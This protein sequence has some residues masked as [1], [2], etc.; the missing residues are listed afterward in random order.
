[1]IALETPAEHRTGT[2]ASGIHYETWTTP[3]HRPWLCLTHGAFCDLSDYL[4]FADHLAGSHNLLL[5][6]LPGHGQSRRAAPAR[7]LSHAS[8]A[9]TRVL[10]DC[11]IDQVVLLGCSF[12]GM[13]AQQFARSQPDRCAALIGYVCVPIFL[14]SVPMPAI[15]VLST[16]LQFAFMPMRTFAG[17]FSRQASVETRVQEEFAQKIASY[18][19]AVRGAIWEAMITGMS[20]EPE[21]EFR[22]PVGLITG[23]LDD[24]FP[25]ARERMLQWGAR[26][27]AGR[28]TDVPGAGHLIHKEKPAAFLEALEAQ[29]ITLER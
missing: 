4:A 29:L 2:T 18:P 5:W 6:D 23:A 9:L 26:L 14:M 8:D 17:P 12:G 11:A 13:V 25:G 15:A 22:C 19:P 3:Q 7:R 28:H 21:L 1:M 16:R 24:R 10:D 27:P 20:D